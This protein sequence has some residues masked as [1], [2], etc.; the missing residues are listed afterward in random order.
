ML[1][2]W[3]DDRNLYHNVLGP[4]ISLLHDADIPGGDAIDHGAKKKNKQHTRR[5]GG[6]N[7]V[8]FNFMKI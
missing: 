7:R 3:K 2:K 8:Y 5:G 1:I 6:K 4:G